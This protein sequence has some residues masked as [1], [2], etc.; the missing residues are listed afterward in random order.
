MTAAAATTP[1]CAPAKVPPARAIAGSG[2]PWAA[3]VRAAVPPMPWMAERTGTAS[4]IGP[5]GLRGTR[6]VMTIPTAA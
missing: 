6:S 2:Q 3:P 4:M 1:S 5:M